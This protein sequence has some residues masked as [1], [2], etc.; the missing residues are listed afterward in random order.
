MCLPDKSMVFT[1]PAPLKVDSL[2]SPFCVRYGWLY[3]II[4]LKAYSFWHWQFFPWGNVNLFSEINFWITLIVDE[5]NKDKRRRKRSSSSNG[6]T[7]GGRNSTK[8]GRT[9]LKRTNSASS[10]LGKWDFPKK[11]VQNTCSLVGLI[12]T[13]VGALYRIA[14]LQ[15]FMFP[16]LTVLLD[17]GVKAYKAAY[18]NN[19]FG[20][21][22]G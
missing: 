21:K 6:S 16:G 10:A 1:Y 14:D 3:T 13:F 19:Y 17:P 2:C 7:S 11:E 15:Y 12:S 4:L 22:V 18:L 9:I 8:K 5:G 20:L